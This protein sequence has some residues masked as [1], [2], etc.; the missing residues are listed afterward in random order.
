MKV[1]TRTGDAGKT[2]LFSGERLDKSDL[3][4]D[5]YGDLDELNAVVGAVAA[6]L[7][8]VN[9]A[10]EVKTQLLEIQSDLFLAGAWLATTA[11]SPSAERL[12][13]FAETAVRRLE[14][15]IDTMQAGLDALTSFILPGGHPAAAWAHVARTICRRAE[16]KAVVLSRQQALATDGQQVL[17]YLNRL[18]DYCFVLARRCNQMADVTDVVWTGAGK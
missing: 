11:G 2:N 13:P 17:P 1:Y 4:V 8:A 7:P 10:E 18:S 12:D 9:G 16:R 14:D 5:A 6:A 15:L 3:R